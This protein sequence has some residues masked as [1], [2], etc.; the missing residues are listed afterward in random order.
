MRKREG[1]RKHG[2]DALERSTTRRPGREVER[3]GQDDEVK[4]DDIAIEIDGLREEL[5]EVNNKWLRALADLDNYKKRVDRERCRWSDESR[6]TILL[7][8]LEVVDNFERAVACDDASAPPPDDPFREGVEMILKHLKDVLAKHDVHALEACGTEFDPNV[9]E[10]VSQV[11]SEEHEPNQI[12]EEV[13]RGYMMG[14]RLLRCSRVIVA[15]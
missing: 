12:V 1:R 7:D 6:E 8:L 5:T 13:Q 3:G 2:S 9:H 11:E 15:K 4:A 10:A 14:D